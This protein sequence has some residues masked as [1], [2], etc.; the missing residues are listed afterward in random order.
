MAKNSLARHELNAQSARFVVLTSQRT[1]STLLVRSLD[2][3]ARI[4]CAGELYRRGRGIYHREYQYPFELLGSVDL[5]K[6]CDVFLS[7]FRIRKHLKS[8]Y[9]AAGAGAEAV[10]FKLMVSQLRRYPAVISEAI[11]MGARPL[12]LYRANT[13]ATALS[14]CRAEATGVFHSDRAHGANAESSIL[15]SE[16]EFARIVKECQSDQLELIRLH[17]I[18]GGLLMRYEDMI[19]DWDAFIEKIGSELGV[20]GL[21][22]S[23]VLSKLRAGV[24]VTHIANEQALIAKFAGT[25]YDGHPGDLP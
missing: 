10:G 13:L 3:S 8:F 12:F 6:F 7:R 9:L 11:N 1:G 20:N 21:R 4:F 25:L 24:D 17:G 15:V 16:Y 18:H 23:K 2:S 22:V 19:A 5:G 14:Y